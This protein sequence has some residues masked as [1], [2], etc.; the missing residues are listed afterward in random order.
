MNSMEMFYHFQKYR[1]IR[2]AVWNFFSPRQRTITADWE[3]IDT[4]IRIII[5]KTHYI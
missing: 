4:D 5:K 2:S 1:K 3:V